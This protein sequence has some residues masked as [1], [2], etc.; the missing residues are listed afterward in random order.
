MRTIKR[1]LVKFCFASLALLLTSVMPLSAFA[2]EQQS[3][4]LEMDIVVESVTQAIET[5]RD[6][7]GQSISSETSF[8][9]NDG[10]AFLRWRVLSSDYAYVQNALRDLGDVRS[11]RE[12]AVHRAS[13]I[14]DLQARLTTNATEIERLLTLLEDSASLEILIAVEQRVSMAEWERDSLLGRLN[15]ANSQTAHVDIIIT[16]RE[17]PSIPVTTS[18]SFGERLGTQ[19]VDSIVGLLGFLG[20]VLVF[21]AAVLI[22]LITLAAFMLPIWLIVRRFKLFKRLGLV[23]SKKMP[24]KEEKSE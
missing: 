1:L 4:T 14:L 23:K 5:I 7:P 19:F 13:E 6:F 16:L 9:E 2:Q 15:L 22:P 24:E 8:R 18:I 3:L 17:N 11:E 12:N 20:N 21:F 10:W